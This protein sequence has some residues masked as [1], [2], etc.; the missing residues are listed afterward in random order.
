MIATIAIPAMSVTTAT[1]VMDVIR[2]IRLTHP[3][4]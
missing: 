1:I 3:P 2:A 4:A